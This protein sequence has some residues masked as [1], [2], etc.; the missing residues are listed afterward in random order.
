[1][2][3]KPETLF[4]ERFVSWLKQLPRTV[5]FSIQQISIIGTPDLIVCIN[6][7]FVALELKSSEDAQVSAVQKYNLERIVSIGGGIA[8]IVAPEGYEKAQVFLS[9][10]ANGSS[11][12]APEGTVF[13]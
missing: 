13:N 9:A 6:G 7:K 2:S 10:L 8:L 1:M 4:R 11:L 3:K 5:V 12:H